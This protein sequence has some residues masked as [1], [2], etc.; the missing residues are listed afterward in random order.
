MAPHLICQTDLSQN[1]KQFIRRQIT[2]P[3]HADQPVFL[4]SIPKKQQPVARLLHRIQQVLAIFFVP[5]NEIRNFR[6]KHFIRHLHLLIGDRTRADI[7]FIF[8]LA[9]I[10][11]IVIDIFLHRR[12]NQVRNISV[13]IDIFT[14]SRR[15]D[16]LQMLRK[17]QLHDLAA[18]LIHHLTVVFIVRLD[19]PH[20]SERDVV[21]RMN[22]IFDRF[23]L[24]RRGIGNDIATDHDIQLF[25]GKH[26]SQAFQIRR[27]GDIDRNIIREQVHMELIRHRHTHNLTADQMRLRLFRPGKFIDRQK[28]L[29]AEVANLADNLLV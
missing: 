9:Q 3:C 23:L 16:V 21:H 13:Q 28:Y 1:G 14:D 22:R 26:L 29:I 7:W 17:L 15:T 8:R 10:Q 20:A 24:I 4:H 27:I 11:T 12:V 2:K 5:Q 25:S 19:I 6:Q 18:D